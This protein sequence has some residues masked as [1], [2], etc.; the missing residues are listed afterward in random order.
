MRALLLIL[1][2]GVCTGSAPASIS[3]SAPAP[4]KK[5]IYYGWNTRDT[6]YVRDHW[7]EMEQMPL[8]GIAIGVALDRTHP[9]VGDG[10]TLNL[11]GWQVF[12]PRKFALNE[13]REAIADLQT[14]RW[15]KFTDN[16]LPVAIATREQDQGLKWFDNARWAT[17]EN[18]WRVLL[19]IARDGGCRGLLIDVEHYD[20]ECELFNYS[21]HRAQRLDRSFAEYATIARQRGRQFGAAVREIFPKAILG[22]LYGYTLPASEVA[23]QGPLNATRYALLPAFLDGLLEASGPE[24]KLVDL[25]EFGHTYQKKEQFLGGR[26]AIKKDALAI[27]AVPAVYRTKVQAGCSLRLDYQPPRARWNTKY[28]SR[29]FFSP[30]RFRRALHAALEVSDRYVWIYSEAGPDFFP[31]KDLP[32]DYLRA[33][34]AARS[35]GPAAAGAAFV[36]ISAGLLGLAAVFGALWMPVRRAIRRRRKQDGGQPLGVLI[37]T[38]IFP[39]DHGG[40]ASYVPRMATA[41]VQRGHRV[42]VICLSDQLDH[43]DTGYPFPVR[44]IL[45][46]AW[47]PGRIART[48]RLIWQVAR[49]HDVIFVNG[50]GSESALAALLAGRPCLHKIVGDYAWERA[51]SKRWF[52]GTLDEYQASAKSPRLQLLDAVRTWPLRT[53]REV[54]VPSRYLAQIVA[55]WGIAPGKIH[56]VYNAVAPVNPGAE[57]AGLLPPWHG[58]TLL[59][60]C[61]LV[62]WKGVD[63]LI[64]LM[65]GLNETR[66]IIAGDGHLRGELESL[67]HVCGVADRVVFLGDVPHSAVRHLYAQADAFVLNSSYEGL[68][69]VVLEAMAASTPVIATDAGGTH[70]VVEHESTG[71]LIP[72]GSDKSLKRAI[73]RLWTEPGLGRRLAEAATARLTKRFDFGT[74]VDSTESAL[75]AIAAVP[76]SSPTGLL[77]ESR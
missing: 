8:D 28:L 41:L 75:R 25:W 51:R 55:G 54:I 6:A 11:L 24:T 26:D 57:A 20:Y 29:N 1:A 76:A 58:R 9:T 44:R 63:A 27:S 40:P 62:R 69:H 67:A 43:D 74:M 23:R 10:S 22:M 53:A 21:H 52:R 72:V 71:L 14:P 39:P 3:V 49:R 34:R 30:A 12:G 35:D 46:R 15:K 19:T 64:R 13:F 32:E 7:A 47:L 33:I 70:E 73:E 77:E 68:P 50:L 17:I 5:V 65:A 37:V 42:E 31:R 18:N 48:V 66:L 59:T 61:R 4:A 38:G 56:V 60:V 2:L 45:R 36:P 16:F